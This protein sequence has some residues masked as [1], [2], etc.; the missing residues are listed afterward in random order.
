MNCSRR[1][2]SARDLARALASIV[3]PV[4]GTSSKRT[5]PSER[6]ATRNSSTTADLPTI[7]CSIW[8]MTGASFGFIEVL[9][10]M[11]TR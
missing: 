2:G 10:K 4:P 5:W 11:V 1:K 9:P 8:A 3:L 6:R 7:T